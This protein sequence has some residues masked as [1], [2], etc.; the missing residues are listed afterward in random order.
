MKARLAQISSKMAIAVAATAVALT[1][2]DWK[3]VA[4]AALW[5]AWCVVED[6][7]IVRSNA[8]L[9]TEMDALKADMSDKFL[10]IQNR[11]GTKL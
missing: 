9:S 7:L 6:V 8:R 2:G 11:L 5:S 3:A 4:L 1:W 10:R